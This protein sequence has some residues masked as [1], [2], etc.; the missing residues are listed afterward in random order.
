MT[1]Y[2]ED[3]PGGSEILLELVDEPLEADD[4]FED[5]GHS[6]EARKILQGLYIG[7]LEQDEAYE[8]AKAPT[9][10]KVSADGTKG[11][12]GLNPLALVVLIIAI[13]AAI[14]FNMQSA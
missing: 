12:N 10:G 9:S 5:I 11:G 8:A 2:M 1:E 14:Y 4:R 13:A 7:D 6:K 3:H